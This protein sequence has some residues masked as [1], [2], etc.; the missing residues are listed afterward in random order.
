MVGMARSALL[1]IDVAQREDLAMT[2]SSKY[3]RRQFVCAGTSGMA[4][5]IVAT[6]SPARAGELEAHVQAPPPAATAPRILRKPPLTEL[7][8]IARSYDLVLSQDDLTSF[9]GLMDGSP[10][11]AALISSRSRRCL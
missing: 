11:I 7:Q 5:T 3:S 6:S 10:R 4:A 8:R 1:R 2:T 9:R